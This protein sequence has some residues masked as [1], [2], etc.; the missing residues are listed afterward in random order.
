MIKRILHFFFHDWSKWEDRD[1]VVRLVEYEGQER[2][3][4]LCGK[5]QVR[6]IGQW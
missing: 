3:C 5:K 1:I 2:R 6:S 4:N